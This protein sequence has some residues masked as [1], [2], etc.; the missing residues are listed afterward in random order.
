MKR[1][2]DLVRSILITAEE[3]D[4]P[5]RLRHAARM[6]AGRLEACLHVELMR[7]RGLVEAIVRYDGP[8]RSPMDAEVSSVTKEISNLISQAVTRYD[9]QK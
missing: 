1:D 4:G 5:R 2:L 9:Q 3:S 7:S 8:T 6:R